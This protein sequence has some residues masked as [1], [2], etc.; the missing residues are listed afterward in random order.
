MRLHTEKA[1]FMF[2][3]FTFIGILWASAFFLSSRTHAVVIPFSSPA[4]FGHQLR[5]SLAPQLAKLP[6][7]PLSPKLLL[8]AQSSDLVFLLLF[9]LRI[10]VKGLSVCSC[11]P[12]S[13]SHSLISLTFARDFSASFGKGKE[14]AAMIES[15]IDIIVVARA[16]RKMRDY[17]F[18]VDLEIRTL[19]FLHPFFHGL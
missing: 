16:E 1:G 9:Q 2:Q 15:T 6:M 13:S 8:H 14:H 10:S 3:A 7:L 19:R 5:S 4:S 12:N 18:L 11:R 17:C